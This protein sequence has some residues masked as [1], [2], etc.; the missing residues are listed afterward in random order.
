MRGKNTRKVEYE[1]VWDED[2][3]DV[4]G[5]LEKLFAGFDPT[6]MPEPEHSCH[7]KRKR[8]KIKDIIDG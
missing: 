7:L 2:K 8:L 5:K 3:R 4:T 1:P 6:T